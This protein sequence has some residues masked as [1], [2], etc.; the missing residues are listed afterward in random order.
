MARNKSKK[1]YLITI[2]MLAELTTYLVIKNLRIINYY[3]KEF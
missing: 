3:I 1:Q 2:L